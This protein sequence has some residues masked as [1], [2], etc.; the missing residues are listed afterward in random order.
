MK[1]KCHVFYRPWCSNNVATVT[2][3]FL[4]LS[5]T[6]TETSYF[7][8]LSPFEYSAFMIC[9]HDFPRGEVS[10]KVGVM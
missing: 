2:F 4:P 10:V 5:A 9:V 8:D 3:T 7:H 6:F 1:V